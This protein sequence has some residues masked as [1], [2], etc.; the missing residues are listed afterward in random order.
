[1]DEPFSALDPLI[2]RELQDELL[3][4][5]KQL[6]KTIV[7]V[8]HDFD[9]AIKVSSRIAVMRDGCIVQCGTAKEILLEPVNDYIRDF[10]SD[11][12]W[13]RI[14]TVSDLKVDTFTGQECQDRISHSTRLKDAAVILR[15]KKGPWAIVNDCDEVQGVIT[16]VSLGKALGAAAAQDPRFFA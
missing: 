4:L 8:T 2:R 14:F 5:Q 13:A 10:V 9:E 15:G 7:F 3:K 1:M 16:K 6:N 11:V 12:E